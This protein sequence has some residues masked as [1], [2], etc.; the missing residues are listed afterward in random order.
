MS[1][2]LY[3]KYGN[4]QEPV[5]KLSTMAGTAWMEMLKEA[6]DLLPLPEARIFLNQCLIDTTVE[7]SAYMLKRQVAEGR[8]EREERKQ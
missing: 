4:H 5:S 2:I 3:N 8:K 6:A 7:I 1:E